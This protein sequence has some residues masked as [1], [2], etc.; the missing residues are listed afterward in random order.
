MTPAQV[1]IGYGGTALL[2]V[3]LAGVL[4]R[5]R[6]DD[7]YSF[8]VYLISVFIPSLLVGLWPSRFFQQSFSLLTERV[9]DGL[10]FAL[11]MELSARIF[12]TFPGAAAILRR[13]LLVVLVLT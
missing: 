3:T 8:P 7:C 4:V 12:R 11:A 5:R 6:Y 9:H 13:V 1:A 10:R 2:A